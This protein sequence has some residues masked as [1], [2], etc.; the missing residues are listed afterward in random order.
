MMEWHVILC[1]QVVRTRYIII[2]KFKESDNAQETVYLIKY[3]YRFALCPIQFG[4]Y[5]GKISTACL[6]KRSC[7]PRKECR[8]IQQDLFSTSSHW[9]SA[10]S[11][12]LITDFR[13][14]RSPP[15]TAFLRLQI[16]SNN[17]F[18]NMSV[19]SL[20]F[21]LHMCTRAYDSQ[22]VAMTLCPKTPATKYLVL[23]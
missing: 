5:S 18:S 20:Y 19:F 14:F 12:L 23:D 1:T 22:S 7:F 4:K 10:I 2:N 11:K 15:S 13:V 21:S 3:T 6:E 16:A 8:C 9:S 17:C